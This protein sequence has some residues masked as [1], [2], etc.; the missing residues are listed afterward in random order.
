MV[1]TR[2]WSTPGLRFCVVDYGT[3]YAHAS[4]IMI[5]SQVL[6]NAYATVMTR[7]VRSYRSIARGRMDFDGTFTLTVN[8]GLH[9]LENLIFIFTYTHTYTYVQIMSADRL[10]IQI[11]SVKYRITDHF[12]IESSLPMK[13]QSSGERYLG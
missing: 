13:R 5:L 9:L 11:N 10:S 1:L 4:M 3:H 8:C 7:I 12:S 6:Q 2:K